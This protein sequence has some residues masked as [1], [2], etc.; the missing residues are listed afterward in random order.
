MK[1][2]L[3]FLIV[4]LIPLWSFAQ[5]C[6]TLMK[7]LS[8]DERTNEAAT[9]IEGEVID[10]RSYWDANRYNIYT[11]HT[12][13]VYKSLKGSSA[14]TE[15]V[16]TMGGKVDDAMQ[17]A[18]SAAHLEKGTTGIFFLKPFAEAL[19]VPGTLNKLVGAAQG[20]IKYDKH[21]DK[22]ADVFFSYDSVENELYGRLQSATRSTFK[23]I[24]E[25]PSRSNARNE[26]RATPV[27]SNF[28]PSSASAGT[29][30][31]LTITGSNFGTTMGEVSFA[32]SNTGGASYVAAIDSQIVSWTDTQIE[33]EIPYLAGTGN[34][35]V[36]NSTSETGTSSANLTVTF[37]HIGVESGGIHYPSALQDDDGNGGFTFQ[38]HTDFD[39]SSAKAYFEEAFGLWNCESDVNFS[40]SGTTTTDV[41]VDD[42]INIVRFDN[43][44]ELA[45]GVLGEVVTR[46]L[47]TCATTGRAVVK[48]LDITWNDSTSWYYGDGTPPSTQ[49][50]FKSV[51]LHE[52]GHAHQLGHVIDNNVIM[53][54]NL[55]AGV[56]KYSLDQNDIDGANFVMGIFTQSV[57]C[58]ITPMSTQI[59]CCDPVTFT[60]QPTDTAIAVDATAQFV[61]DASNANTYQWFASTDG[62]SFTPIF[63]DTIYSGALTN[64]L[65]IQNTPATYDGYQ[66][67]CL[68]S[69]PCN[70]A[71][72][73]DSATL[74]V[75]EYTAIPDANFEAR[76]E[77]LGHDDISG[78]GQVPTAQI[79]VVTNLNVSEEGISDLTGIEAFTALTTLDCSDNNLT[80]LDVSANL[81]LETLK[82]QRNAI[83]VIDLSN[84][85]ALATLNISDNQLS[86]LNTTNNTMLESIRAFNNAGLSV[87]DVT[88]NTVLESLWLSNTV[89]STLDLSNN[90]ALN[91]LTI[92]SSN[93]ADLD[94][95]NNTLLRTI[96]ISETNIT[97]LDLSAQTALEKLTALN[98]ILENLDI[99]SGSNDLITTFRTT[100]NPNLA[101]ALVDDA[102][103]STT[104]WTEVDTG[105]VFSDTYCVY[106][107]IPDANFE[108]ALE[109]LGYDD[110]SGDGQV[111][112]ALIESVTS[113]NVSNQNI[114]SLIG[115]EDFTALEVLDFENNTVVTVDLSNISQLRIL[116][117]QYN[118]LTSLD[119]TTNTNLT[120]L[121]CRNNQLSALDVSN[122]TALEQLWCHFNNI[123]TLDL[124]NNAVLRAMSFRDNAITS[125]DLSN[126]TALENLFAQNNSISTMDLVNNVNLQVV[127]FANNTL[128]DFNIKNG[129]NTSITNINLTGNTD[130]NCVL[131]DDA[132][133]STNNWTN[134]DSGV[135]FNEQSCRYTLIPDSNFES[136]LEALGYDDISGDGQVPTTLI[137]VVTSLDVS[138][139][140]I[141]DLT[142]IEDFTALVT[143][144]CS[145]NALG[146]I[147]LSN[148]LLLETLS[149]NV[150]SLTALDVSTNTALRSLSVDSNFLTSIDLSN[151][152]VLVNLVLYGNQLNA[153][154][155]SNNTNIT[156]IDLFQN[157]L[158]ALDFSNNALLEEAYIDNNSIERLDFSNNPLLE[159]LTCND[160][161][162]TRL[163]LRNGANTNLSNANINVT[164][165]PNLTCI[166]VDNV[167]YSENT[168]NNVDAGVSF[169]ETYCRYTAI[170]DSNF[171]TA[172][173]AL[174]YDDISNDG[175]VPTALI[176]VITDLD[177][178]STDI[179]D[180]T[181]IEEFSALVNL[182]VDQNEIVSLDL[183]ANLLLESLTCINNVIE[184]LDF[185][186]LPALTSLYAATNNLKSLNLQNGNY[187]NFTDLN[188]IGNGDLNCILVDDKAYTLANWSYAINGVAANVFSDT[189]CD[190][191]AIPDR[192]FEAAL[193]AL[194]YDDISGDGQVPTSLIEVVTTLDVRSQ[195]IADFTGIEAFTSL[196]ILNVSDNAF[197][198]INLSNNVLL[199][200]INISDN[201]L[202]AIDVSALTALTYLNAKECALNS[203]D[204]SANT[205]LEF[206]DIEESDVSSLDIS[207]NLLLE[208]LDIGNNFMNS[209]TFGQN[210]N[211]TRLIAPFNS[212]TNLDL[213]AL[214]ALEE[215]NVRNNNL[216]NLDLRNG[217]NTNIVSF[218]AQ[219]NSLA[220]IIVDD[221][222]YATANWTNI[223][224]T[225]SFNNTDCGYTY[226]PDS[227]FEAA[228]DAL[229]YDDI[230]SDN[231][232]PT[233]SIEVII[234]LDLTNYGIGDLTGIKD[235]TSL[236]ILTLTGNFITD[237]DLSG[238]AT[239]QELHANQSINAS[240]DISNTPSLRIVSCY[241][242]PVNAIDLDGATALEE[243]IAYR[244]D[245]SQLDVSTNTALKI[246]S[247][248]ESNV[249]TL[250]LNGAT[251][252]EELIAY[253]TGLTSLDVSTNSA[254]KILSVYE[255]NVATL[256]LNGATA[257]EELIAYR[258]NLTSLDLSTNSVLK[259]VE[260]YEGVGSL[261]S[262]N[263]NGAIALEELYVYFNDLTSIDVSNNTALSV[264]HVFSNPLTTLDVDELT[265]LTNLNCGSSDIT[266]IDLSTNTN[267]VEFS[268]QN[269][270]IT[271]I[272]LSANPLLEIV[273]MDAAELIY[274]NM[275]NGN[276]TN[277][278]RFEAELNDNL[279]CILVDDAAYSTANWT[280]IDNQTSFNDVS[281]DVVVAPKVYL[282]GAS[283][284]PYTG[285]ENLMR[286]DLR[287]N[288]YISSQTPF[289]DGATITETVG[290]D[291][292]GSNSMVDWVWVELRDATDQTVVV[293]GQSAVLQRD[294]DIV[295]T[296][297]DLVTPL[298]FPASP[299]Q[300]YVV[301]KHRN[302]LGIMTAAAISLNTVS[303]TVDF[304]D[305]SSQITYGANAQTTAGMPS[306]IAGMWAG[307]ANA[308]GEIVFLNTGAESVD[309]KQTVLDVSA[310][311]SPFGASVFYKPQGYYD[312][313]VNMDGEVIFLNAG[314]ELLFIKDNILAHPSNQIFNSVFYKIAQ[315]LP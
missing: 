75:I 170:P 300:Y 180:M 274:F 309:I 92:E 253:R 77:A 114:S 144:D 302:H 230:A 87:V 136:A 105:L 296:N 145:E 159:A 28:S 298:T 65:T 109:T 149:A 89:L 152:T 273:D 158:T 82:V 29:Q 140:T 209:I 189:Y 212:F 146:T 85:T 101:C 181:G 195:A 210:T 61:A 6:G 225:T 165:N 254:L 18:S 312:A 154:D 33:V 125:I 249:G 106:T 66:Y 219:N 59:N 129:N 46:F 277:I 9:I 112:T 220:C 90:P 207:N 307:D 295:S 215:I 10:S 162:L 280:Q 261:N 88:Q 262:I 50:D 120:S 17:I 224:N 79:E 193:E 198:S 81:M 84:N 175:Q 236:E 11:V 148:N 76:L 27:I 14:R 252:L 247:V 117:C 30:T 7:P 97:S 98:C 313:D 228:L 63:D 292:Q 113:L 137:E 303:T 299:G 197:T 283:V 256:N 123:S 38:Y 173:E 223:D 243:L 241:E 5:T 250:N 26:S 121:Y 287:S 133:Y 284:N 260:C 37:N 60:T 184:H 263:L 282:Q 141:T 201:S 57:G 135:I 271:S 182:N 150:C 49:H 12:I 103:Y 238:H 62:V 132:T 67:S 70:E 163:D 35:R 214:S 23:I 233:S 188:T 95:S 275:K 32:N 4:S 194:G 157:Q 43:G 190:Y 208:D 78:D 235:F 73:S 44:A 246:L 34:I 54:Y 288:G 93:I 143:L 13:A 36:T 126:N 242:A 115:I 231:Q 289:G 286:D 58:G 264:L 131:V 19:N 245:V 229:G 268:G 290:F 147:D 118:N 68:I 31:V 222:A 234:N 86:A 155:L 272:D 306:G 218:D 244:T 192:N 179:I 308:D 22:A 266:S 259:K 251:A 267:L 314:N 270:K 161:A 71:E 47:G 119:V 178:S 127:T 94:L 205:L 56:S 16:V 53:H 269:S 174:G 265:A 211:L 285:E 226:I 25:R 187:L 294:G 151:N 39:T 221:E 183:S 1:K 72:M 196:A 69:N 213:R 45:S 172:L 217:N 311:E 202:N 96:N 255:S 142:G 104:N 227:A 310:V 176:E 108:A 204:V 248:Y 102:V 21:S 107:T 167:T 64:T 130:L 203:L 177:V 55:G 3:L 279:T 168:W 258:T 20:L 166:L 191:T 48:E 8:I 206:L 83:K 110:I 315:Q 42:G 156:S 185:S 200:E 91:V 164:N 40:F 80:S 237:L 240:L 239:I 216:T 199:S 2:K 15:K 138:N 134:I 186:G 276:N 293:A 281:C 74:A 171:E 139:S 301:I 99:R 100:N 52:L 291:N 116:R 111:P 304:T 128:T 297:D 169:S 41:S 51:A 122:N 305:A 257:L 24:Q 153:L 278:T 232:V 160:N 124:T